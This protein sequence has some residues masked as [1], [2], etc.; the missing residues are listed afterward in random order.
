[1]N[2]EAP[3]DDEP[4][5]AVR[6]DGE[7]LRRLLGDH[8]GLVIAGLSIMLIAIRILSLVGFQPAL[9]IAVVQVGDLAKI[10]LATVIG[11]MPLAFP[12]LALA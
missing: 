5:A 2:A 6:L 11:M 3:D 7:P 4:L 8:A 9:A 10:V 12:I 1:V